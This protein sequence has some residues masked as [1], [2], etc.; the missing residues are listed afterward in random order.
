MIATTNNTNTNAKNENTSA[1]TK[2]EFDEIDAILNV[3]TKSEEDD[4]FWDDLDKFIQMSEEVS[5]KKMKLEETKKQLAVDI[6]V[7][8]DNKKLESILAVIDN[9]F[10]LIKD[11]E[12]TPDE[13]IICEKEDEKKLNKFVVVKKKSKKAKKEVIV[14]E[15]KEEKVVEEKEKDVIVEEKKEEKV[16]KEKKEDVEKKGEESWTAMVSKTLPTK[17]KQTVKAFVFSVEKCVKNGQLQELINNFEKI[18]DLYEVLEFS[19]QY[20][21][22]QILDWV[23]GRI[24][25]SNLSQEEAND[26]TQDVKYFMVKMSIKHDTN[27]LLKKR[28][29][30]YITRHHANMAANKNDCEVLQ[31]V[32]NNRHSKFQTDE[33]CTMSG[34]LSAYDNESYDAVKWLL[35]NTPTKLNQFAVNKMITDCA[36]CGDTGLL[37][38]L[39]KKGYRVQFRGQFCIYKYDSD[40]QDIIKD[41]ENKSNIKY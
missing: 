18:K 28:G 22:E 10:E 30:Y 32:L 6:Q 34:V 15:K 33:L 41:Y 24:I 39:Y 2:K 5:A 1:L 21:K 7:K 27:T 25:P 23:M 9:C 16:V 35:D 31:W 13:E 11:I 20:E 26:L 17:M 19:I 37:E 3:N 36:A 29:P 38:S 14:E 4:T 12:N 8:R 40:V